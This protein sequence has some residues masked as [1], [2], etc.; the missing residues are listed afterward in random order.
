M[1][2][3]NVNTVLMIHLPLS[4]TFF[5]YTTLF[6]SRTAADLCLI[7]SIPDHP[8]THPR[9]EFPAVFHFPCGSHYHY[10]LPICLL[11]YLRNPDEFCQMPFTNYPSLLI[12][13]SDSFPDIHRGELIMSVLSRVSDKRQYLRPN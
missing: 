6:R 3:L 10:N 12:S 5:P 8:L 9:P 1:E 2:C 7:Y 11:K 4:C 13:S